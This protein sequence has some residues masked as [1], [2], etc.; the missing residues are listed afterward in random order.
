[1]IKLVESGG[2]AITATGKGNMRALNRGEEEG[3][4]ESVCVCVC[5]CVCVLDRQ[6]F[7]ERE[8]RTGVCV[9]VC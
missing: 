5:V 2:N 8:A 9:C 7:L 4:E 6:A 1:M 3:Q